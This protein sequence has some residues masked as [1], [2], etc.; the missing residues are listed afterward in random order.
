[1][2]LCLDIGNS[3]IYGGV[4]EGE[5][6]KLQF[7]K[8]STA[9][10]TSDEMG[11]FLL[12]VLRE[13]EIAPDQI[14]HIAVCSVVPDALYSVRSCCQKYFHHDP[15]VLQPGVKTG[16]KIRYH[17]PQE[18]GADRIADAIAGVHLHPG[19]NLIIVDFGT[20]TTI[21]AVSKSKEFLGG[22]ILPGVRLAMEALEAK[23][24]KL[25]LVEIVAPQTSVGRSTV[26]S[27]QSGIYWS[28]VGAIKEL[29]SR[30]TQEV[31]PDDAPLVLA[32]GGFSHFFD[33]ENLFDEI[34]PDLILKGLYLAQSMNITTG[35]REQKSLAQSL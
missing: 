21:C 6:L 9:R 7:R 15:L 25:P 24:A 4:F 35:Q 12:G 28:N 1:M 31:F 22:N 17:N 32:T 33:R 16:L 3:Q 23:T 11:V 10:S 27:I 13:N 26:E 19:R 34:V 2:I 8:N 20:A 14:E 29:L 5:G 30:I 18:V